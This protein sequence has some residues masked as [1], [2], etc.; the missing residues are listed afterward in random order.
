MNYRGV[1]IGESLGNTDVLR[2][3]TVVST[4]VESVTEKHRT[5]W[6]Q[7]WTL[8]TV[9]VPEE[10]AEEIAAKVSRSLEAEHPWYADFK[11][12]SRHYLI[13]RDK[14]FSVDRRSREQYD[15]VKRYG[16]SLGIPEYQVD[17]SSEVV[18]VL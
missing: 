3:L 2:E 6:L 5:P 7:Q 8:H 17:F 14:V 18:P 4:E 12:D 1:I 16:V 15:E 11:N 9:E 13:F 10:R